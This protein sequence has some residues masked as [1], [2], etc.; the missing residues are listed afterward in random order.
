M[1]RQVRLVLIA[2]IVVV[3]LGAVAALLALNPPA[4]E[5]GGVSLKAADALDVVQVDIRNVHD[6]ISVSF[7]GEGYLVD[8]IPADLV[9]APDLIDLLTYSGTV[10]TERT[11]TSEPR[12][13]GLYG[14][15]EPAARVAVT[16]ADGSALALLIGDVERVSDDTYFQVEGDP[17]VYL[18]ASE[19]CASFL[20]PKKAF[21][22]DLVTPEL[23]LS[24]PL[25]ALLDVTFSGG[26]LAA[27][28]TVEAVA[29]G[30][31]NVARAAMSFGA[32]THIV[33]GKGVYELDQ[34][35]GVEML[36]ALLGITAGD[37][38]GYNLTPAE[39][40]A[41]GFDRPTMEVAFDLKNGLD[42][43]V[44]HYELALL[45]KDGTTYMTRNDDGVIYV[46]PAPAFLGLAYPKL[47]VR[48]FLSPLLIDVRRIVVTTG[49]ET[50]DFVITGETAAEK[51]VTCNGED[52]DI[53]RFRDLYRLL[54]SAAHDGRLL[55]NVVVQGPP[56]LELTYH[57]IDEQKPP[58]VMSLY[59]GDARRLYVQINGVTELAMEE[60]YLERV[61]EALD[62][63]WTDE[64]IETEW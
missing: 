46:V 61:Q 44:V 17:T 23:A 59:P 40:E 34:T 7:T 16:Y 20:V 6:T 51:R 62:I 37:I 57:Y 47:L 39:I 55:G 35:Y 27:P 48:W 31:P 41:F 11:V 52:L 1:L 32:P 54:T 43:E 56:L 58:D 63:L 2:G 10:L 8:D 18:M 45:Q 53:E 9:D 19:R 12:D 36:G 25:S 4:S 29:S 42:A 22:E 14:L 64:P 24:S 3:L 26:S 13:L 21:V 33:R 60:T 15:S 38:V 5:D 30:D 49:G 28:V 50:Y